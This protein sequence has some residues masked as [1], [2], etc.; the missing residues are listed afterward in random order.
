MLNQ[1]F[2]T[3]T[4]SNGNTSLLRD[5]AEYGKLP[6]KHIASAED[7]KAYK[8]HPEVYNGAAKKLGL[9]TRECGLIAA[10]LGDLQ[11]AKGCGYQTIYIERREEETWDQEK[12]EK[13]KKDGWVDMWLGIDEGGFE[14]VAKRFGCTA[15]EHGI[16]HETGS[17]TGDA[18]KGAGGADRAGSLEEQAKAGIYHE[19]GSIV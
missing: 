4:L 3:A 14:E 16:Y 12:V 17:I 9:Q 8:P 7:F 1:K 15:P 10:H 11:A 18:A 5:L 2:E 13:A 6:Y 19:D